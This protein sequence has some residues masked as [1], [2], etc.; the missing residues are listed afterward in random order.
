[1][2]SILEDAPVIG[3]TILVIYKDDKFEFEYK[4]NTPMKSITS[5]VAV[6]DVAPNGMIIL[7]QFKPK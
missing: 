5:N 2:K 7:D 6:P 4:N 3:T 1:S